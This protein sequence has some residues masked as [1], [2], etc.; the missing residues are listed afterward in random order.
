MS[1]S[2]N[3]HTRDRQRKQSGP[4]VSVQMSDAHRSE[5]LETAWNEGHAAK[6]DK[7]KLREIFMAG[8]AWAMSDCQEHRGIEDAPIGKGNCS[9][10]YNGIDSYLALLEGL[11]KQ[12]PKEETG[13]EQ[14]RS[15]R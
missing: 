14:G 3:P 4:H 6:Y 15:Q 2:E 1:K 10:C 8:V 12:L 11:Q 9:K 7:V 13:D 5:I